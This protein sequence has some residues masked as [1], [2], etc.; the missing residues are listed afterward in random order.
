MAAVFH[1]SPDG[2]DSWEGTASRPFRTI[3][4]G[5]R[6][7]MAGDTV[8]V[9]EG[10]YREWVKPER[11]GLAS[12]S[13]ITYEAASGEKVVI[14]GSER[15]SNWENAEGTVW[16][17]CL[18]NAFFGSFNPYQEALH[19]D[20][21]SYPRDGSVHLGD[22][23]LN[24]QS[25]YEAKSLEEVK[26]PQIRTTGGFKVRWAGFEHDLPHPEQT[27]YQW[28][29]SVDAETT[30]IYA[31]FHSHNPNEELT[32]INVR[33]CCFY[34]EK[35]GLNYITVRGFEMAHAACPWTPPT[36]DQVGM[37]GPH[38][39]K[40][41]IIENN[42]LHDA[43]CSAIS[44]GK[45]GSTGGDNLSTSTF[46]KSGYQYQ[47]EAVF[48]AVQAGWSKDTIG[49]HVIRSNVIYDCGQNGIVGHL[50]CIGSE[51]YGNHIYNIAQ[52][53]EFYGHEV[54]GIKLHTAIDV[55][56]H[57]NCIH[58]C[59]LGTW[60]DW[61]AQGA[62]LSKNLYYHNERD[63]MIEVTHGPHLVDNNIFASGYNL[64][65]FAQGG[66]YV[67]NLWAGIMRLSNVMDRST[68]YHFPHST[69]PAGCAFV[70][71]KDERV[72]NN[73]YTAP[74]QENPLYSS[75]TAAYNGSP[76]SMD[77]YSRLVHEEIER[78]GDG[79]LDV[80]ARTSQPVYIDCNAYFCGAG[81]YEGEIHSFSGSTDP[82]VKVVEEGD[83][84][85]L[86][87][88]VEAGMAEL[89][90]MIHGTETLGIVR[91]ADQAFEAADGSA[92]CL[93]TDY[94]GC[95]RDNGWKVGPVAQLAEG[96]NRIKVWD[97]QTN[98]K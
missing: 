49:S 42:I 54:A 36:A 20:W 64:D 91:I 83:G 1:I 22:V 18:P 75:G 29:A 33:P 10:V 60:L 89:P 95:S 11:G 82:Q 44:I 78:Q 90:G 30:T 66:A 80:F 17:V 35:T 51:I 38:W 94:F 5:A 41:W 43:K 56:I 9:H 71:G 98:R 27:L 67:N 34:P 79:D 50:G 32:E 52:K 81:G 15:I 87:W 77:A 84:I 55:H 4:R 48:R 16:K 76:T 31:N 93:D 63:L 19:G 25:F 88:T 26:N 92:I 62:R 13:R 65:N 8:L 3:S 86:E 39:S 45:D 28:F 24:G 23:Y 2:C 57:D 12:S 69:Q 68:P 6:K 21:H 70:F 96:R 14:K 72:Y 58:H 47:M 53:K 85:Y 73:V 7:A 40:G 97:I 37:L 61:E 46:R 74:Q 59:T